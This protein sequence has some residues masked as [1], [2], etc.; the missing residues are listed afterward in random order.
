MEDVRIR[1]KTE[2]NK[3]SKKNIE[4][5]SKLTFNG[6]HKSYTIYDS[7]TFKRNEV[8]MDKPTYLG[9]AV[10]ELSKLLMYETFY[11]KL[12]PY[13]GQDKLQLHYLGCVSFFLNFETQNIVK[14][15]KN[16]ECLFDFS[17]LDENRELIS[18]KNTKIVGKYKIATSKNFWINDFFALRSEAYSFKCGDKNTNKLKG[19]SK[20]YSKSNKFEEYKKCL[21]DE[22]YVKDCDNYISKSIDH[23]IYP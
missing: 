20:I 23:E 13:F 15:L 3:F 7:Y 17:N 8:L 21:D 4:Q 18:N 5:Q 22:K 1:C 9:Y 2:F 16:R 10:L 14:D 6:I 11:D 12:Q 19:I